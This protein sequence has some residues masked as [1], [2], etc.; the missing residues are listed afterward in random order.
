[1]LCCVPLW[2][3]HKA[4]CSAI[5]DHETLKPSQHAVTPNAIQTDLSKLNVAAAV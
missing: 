1:M 3:A 4:P 2:I 5:L